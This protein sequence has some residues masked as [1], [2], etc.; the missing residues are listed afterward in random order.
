MILVLFVVH[1]CALWYKSVLYSCHPHPHPR[2]RPH[3]HPQSKAHSHP[4]NMSMCI[5]YIA[6]SGCKS[7]KFTLV[8]P[9]ILNREVQGK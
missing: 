9:D 3:P 6:I 5:I 7:V 2:P 8:L 4:H 1:I